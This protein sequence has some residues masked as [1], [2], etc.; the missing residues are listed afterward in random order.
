[1]NPT[2]TAQ[3]NPNTCLFT[4]PPFTFSANA[5][6]KDRFKNLQNAWRGFNRHQMR[7]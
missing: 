6:A 4:L 7:D 5:P 3:I 2:I 1:M